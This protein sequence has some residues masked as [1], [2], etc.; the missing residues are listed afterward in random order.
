M[1]NQLTPDQKLAVAQE[2][3]S[4]NQCDGCMSGLPLDINYHHINDKG[5]PVLA[6][7]KELYKKQTQSPEGEDVGNG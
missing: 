7:C 1:N 6:C 5:R 2:V 3:V 4:V